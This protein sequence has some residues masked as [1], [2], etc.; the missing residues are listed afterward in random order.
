VAPR[1]PRSSISVCSGVGGL[2]L[3]LSRACG[4]EPVVYIE[5]E[6]FA[7]GVLVARMEEAR[8][9]QAPIWD[10]VCTFDARPWCGLVDLVAGG[11]PCQDLSVAGK[12]AGLDGARS[13]LFFEHVRIAVECE[14]PFFFWENVAGAVRVVPRV[15]EYLETR[16]YRSVWGTLKASDVGAPHQRAR[17]FLLAYNE[18]FGR[19][20]GGQP[21]GLGLQG[22]PVAACGGAPVGGPSP[23][24][25]SARFGE[26]EP[27]HQ[28]RAEPRGRAWGSAGGG[29][30]RLEPEEPL[31]NCHGA[32]ERQPGGTL[33]NERGCLS[34]DARQELAPP[35]RSRD[36]LGTFPPSRLDFEG[37][38][39]VLAVRPEL[40]PALPQPRVRGVADGVA[41]RV[42]HSLRTD[43][44][45]ACGNGVVDLQ[46]AHAWCQLWAA[47]FL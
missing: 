20:E 9:A 38:A 3:G 8:L 6:A 11:T 4:V 22:R 47:L 19:G 5:R 36:G 24:A 30:V 7:A 37:W 17:V 39:R 18:V 13:R 21:G 28:E 44:L 42:D 12:R 15:V 1:P 2:D 45:R 41:G 16:G 31:A 25:H 32:R 34:G 33:A 27:H 14:A 40:A 46:A 26:R 23:M 29:G 43:R 10:D 35:Q